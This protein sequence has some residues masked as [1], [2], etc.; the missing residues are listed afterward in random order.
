ML[1]EEN[2]LEQR[3]PSGALNVAR[4]QFEQIKCPMDINNADHDKR[5]IQ[6]VVFVGMGGSA[7]S[8]LVAK[9]WL[10]ESLKVP[11]EIVRT[12]ELPGYVDESTL[13][14]ASSYSGNTEETLSGLESAMSSLAQVCIITSGGKLKEIANDKDIVNIIVPSGI[15]PRM[16]TIYQLRAL[17]A[18]MVHFGTIDSDRLSEISDT[19]DWLEGETQKLLSSVTTSKN[20]A[21]QLAILSVGKTAIFYAGSLMFPIAYKWK[22]SW[23]ENA[24]NVAFCN[25]IPEFNHNEFIGWTSHPVEKPYV[26]FDIISQFEHPQILKRFEISDRLLSGRRP[27]SHTIDLIG[28]SVIK[29]MLWGCVLADFASIYTGILNGVDPTPVPL[30]EKLKTEL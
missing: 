1:D 26:V 19:A 28:D 21:K 10:K 6:K 14:I 11:F 23:N 29:Q 8:A 9:T 13:V 16:T 2:V 20:L 22:I 18:L 25:E 30:I 27:K 4:K 15:Q 3:D 24:K 17:T 5:V 7:L 12:Y